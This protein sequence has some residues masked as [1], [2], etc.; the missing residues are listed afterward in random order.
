M[1]RY[2]E[3]PWVSLERDATNDRS[4]PDGGTG[5]GSSRLVSVPEYPSKNIR[6]LWNAARHTFGSR[7]GSLQYKEK[8]IME[9]GGRISSQAAKR[10][11]HL[12]DVAMKGAAER[13]S[14]MKPNGTAIEGH[15]KVDTEA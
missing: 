10:Y 1:A 13:L 3:S 2:L 11:L 15:S 7:L 12:H 9:A 5:P 14:A 4:M 6:Q 8:A